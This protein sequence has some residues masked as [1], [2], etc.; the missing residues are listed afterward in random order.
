MAEA[1]KAHTLTL[2]ARASAEITG[3]LEVI[4]F[5]ESAVVLQTQAGELTLEG[6]GLRV[7]VLD[8]AGGRLQVSGE[9]S[10]V[11]YSSSEAPRKGRF[12]GLFH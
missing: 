3:V 7:G 2:T 6:T 8:I 12:K 5:D 10:G 11:F 4:S 1:S 9:V